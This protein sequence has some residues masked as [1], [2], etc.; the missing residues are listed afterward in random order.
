M[1][2]GSDLNVSP[3]FTHV[4]DNMACLD[5]RRTSFDIRN[6]FWWMIITVHSERQRSTVVNET[7]SESES[8]LN[9]QKSVYWGLF[10]L[11]SV[12]LWF[13]KREQLW[14][15]KFCWFDNETDSMKGSSL[16]KLPQHT[17]PILLIMSC[18]NQQHTNKNNWRLALTFV[19]GKF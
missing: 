2:H 13:A 6:L 3:Q 5:G 12:V 15:V 14:K 7:F 18:W 17:W 11:V 1:H 8:F 19:V 4:I 9:P 16:C 10:S